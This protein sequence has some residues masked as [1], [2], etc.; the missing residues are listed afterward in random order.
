MDVEVEV[1]AG[2]AASRLG[3]GGLNRDYYSDAYLF[4]A[5]NS[6]HILSH[7]A[8]ILIL[9]LILTLA[10]TFTFTFTLSIF[11][12][13]SHDNCPLPWERGEITQSGEKVRIGEKVITE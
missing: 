9:I 3:A 5:D 13:R 2:T 4:A 10:L 1:R 8:L 11:L 6:A 7:F 12:V